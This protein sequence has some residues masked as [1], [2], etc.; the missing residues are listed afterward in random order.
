M[1]QAMVL[2]G[3][4]NLSAVLQPGIYALVYRR[5]VV[6]VGKSNQML[7]RVYEHRNNRMKWLQREPGWT[8]LKSIPF[9]DV[10]VM[11]VEE[12]RLDEVEREM[13]AKYRPKYNVLLVPKVAQLPPLTI[14]GVIIGAQRPQFHIERRI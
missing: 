9:D 13:I 3:F 7:R 6:Y 4:L 12:T 5:E 1:E 10:F 11:P 2:E 14:N 8:K